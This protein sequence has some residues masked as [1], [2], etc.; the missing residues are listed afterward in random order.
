MLNG[1]I[2]VKQYAK[3]ELNIQLNQSANIYEAVHHCIKEKEVFNKN[4]IAT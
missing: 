2:T 4:L 3:S 1:I